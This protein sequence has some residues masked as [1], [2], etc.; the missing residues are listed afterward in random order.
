MKRAS[1]PQVLMQALYV[2]RKTF[3]IYRH[4]ALW[5]THPLLVTI[6]HHQWINKRRFDHLCR[7]F[8]AQTPLRLLQ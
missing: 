6:S 8:F 3:V 5:L 7:F 1:S 4:P 2:T